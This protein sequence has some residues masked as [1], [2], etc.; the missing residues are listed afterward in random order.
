MYPRP[1][2]YSPATPKSLAA[3]QL[4][5]KTRLI[6]GTIVLIL[7][8]VSIGAI[9]HYAIQTSNQYPSV[10]DF[11]LRRG[12]P[13]S[14]LVEKVGPPNVETPVQRYSYHIPSVE[15]VIYQTD[16]GFLHLVFSNTGFLV[17]A[18]M[19]YTEGRIRLLISLP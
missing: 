17:S 18:E 2:R 11:D 9:T 15:K 16:A 5:T 8:T 6:V 14:E 13:Y 19:H 1:E 7:L 10:S 4:T 12:M 3:G